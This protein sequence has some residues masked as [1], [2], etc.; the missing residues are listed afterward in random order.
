MTVGGVVW[1]ESDS[2]SHSP[3]DSPDIPQNIKMFCATNHGKSGDNATRCETG[4][5]SGG[6]LSLVFKL[7]RPTDF[8]LRLLNG[9]IAVPQNR[10]DLVAAGV[11]KKIK[12]TG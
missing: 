9:M 4:V 8:A 7:W 2:L 11:G 1:C 3:K 12:P 10:L 6:H 5:A